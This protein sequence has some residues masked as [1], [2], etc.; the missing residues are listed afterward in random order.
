[1][2]IALV[3]KEELVLIVQRNRG[4]TEVPKTVKSSIV[5]GDKWKKVER[6][7]DRNFRRFSGSK[8]GSSQSHKERI[9]SRPSDLEGHVA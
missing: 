9:Q 7:G 2:I 6:F 3:S 1:L 4:L 8:Q 5:G